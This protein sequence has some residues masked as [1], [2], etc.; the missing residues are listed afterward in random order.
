MSERLWQNDFA[1]SGKVAGVLA[2]GGTRN[3]GQE[4]T[5][6]AVQVSLFCQEMIRGAEVAPR[7]A[8]G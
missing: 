4:V 1:L 5:I 2:C 7:L 8:P 6:H 3:G